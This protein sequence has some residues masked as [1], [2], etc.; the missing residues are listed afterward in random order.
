[1][2]AHWLIVNGRP[3]IEIE[4]V[5]IS[6]P[7]EPRWLLADTGAGSTDSDFELLLKETDCRRVAG[8]PFQ[9]IRLGGAYR[10]WFPVYLVGIRIPTLSFQS[11]ARAVAAPSV[12][13]GL[14]GIAGFRLLNRFSYGNFGD[15]Q[16]FGLETP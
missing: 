7:P 13:N 2:R 11:Y 9:S 12:P 6:G 14:D 3:V 8:R 5:G 1:V 16:H 15:P 10:G 4:L